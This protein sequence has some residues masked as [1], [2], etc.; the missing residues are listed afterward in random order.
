MKKG[1]QA[2]LITTNS[3]VVSH[4]KNE[5]VLSPTV[6]QKIRKLRLLKLENKTIVKPANYLCKDAGKYGQKY[7]SLGHALRNKGDRIQVFS[8]QLLNQFTIFP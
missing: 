2:L 1:N 5:V 6:N 8:N 4:Y 7:S 3:N